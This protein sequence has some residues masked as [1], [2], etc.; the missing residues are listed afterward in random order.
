M[1]ILLIEHDMDVAFEFAERITVLYQ[2]K[3]LAEGTKEEI[4]NNPTVQEIYLGAE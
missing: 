1:T 4:K 3:F 2:G